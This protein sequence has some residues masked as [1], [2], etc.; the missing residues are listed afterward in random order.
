MTK[1]RLLMLGLGCPPDSSCLTALAKVGC[2][3]WSQ[4]HV[5]QLVAATVGRPAAHCNNWVCIF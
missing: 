4:V 2:E 5:M 1:A 3:R